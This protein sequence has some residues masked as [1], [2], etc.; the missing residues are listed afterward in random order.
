M[1]DHLLQAGDCVIVPRAHA[2]GAEAIGR[3]L[4]FQEFPVPASFGLEPS[5]MI[6]LVRVWCPGLEARED[7][8]S[9][10]LHTLRD[11]P[12]LTPFEELD[13]IPQAA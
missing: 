9:Y 7:A 2:D 10:G 12:S 4:S 11:L 5:G 6:T 1:S 13:P 3:I 8:S